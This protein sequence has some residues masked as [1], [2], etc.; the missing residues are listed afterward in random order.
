MINV[1]NL[2][3]ATAGAAFRQ[4]ELSPVE[5]TDR[6]L[7]TI[8]QGNPI[9]N[10]YLT[11]TAESARIQARAAAEAL[12]HGQDQGP[13]LGIPLA[14]KDLFD[15]AGVRTT[16]GSPILS[17]NVPQADSAV[18]ERLRAAGAVLLGKTHLHEWALGVTSINPHF[19]PCHNPWR[20]DHIAG[21]SSGGSAAAVAAGLCLGA[22]GSDTGGSI[23]I[24]AALC[25]VVGLKPTRGR[26]SLRGVIPLSWSLDHVGPLARTVRDV[27]LLLQAVAGYDPAD[28]TSVDVPVDDYVSGLGRNVAGM[29][30]LVPTNFF[31]ERSSPEVAAL[32][33]DALD[34][35]AALGCHLI[36]VELPGIEDLGPASTRM[37][38]SDAAAYHAQH[39]AERP[40]DI[41]ADVL[42]RL[43]GGEATTG[44]DYARARQLQRIWRRTLAT[45]LSGDTL[46]ATPTTAIPAFPIAGA[47]SVATA[48]RLTAFTAPF[49][50]T[51]LPAISVP[52]GFTPSGLPVGLQLVGRPW[53]ETLVLAVADAY[54]QATG[55]HT[56]RPLIAYQDIIT[57]G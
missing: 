26:V 1:D 42:A 53:T 34:A 29:R 4:G 2:T 11:V 36:P 49:N 37:N 56:R 7:A 40:A 46:L 43:R 51:G 18:A 41:G 22:F 17:T 12:A 52:C 47:D 28:P 9:L 38:V 32:V 20:T 16:A 27:A 30:V 48:G 13:L 50:L 55:W 10:A 25:G 19:G 45:L 31:F 21:G 57:H 8:E 33:Q 44:P 15:V 24:P 35:L 23:R 6:L 14:L 5:L 54:E 3:I 39:L